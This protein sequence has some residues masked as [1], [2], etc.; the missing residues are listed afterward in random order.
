M[1]Q[2]SHNTSGRE[3]FPLDC[4]FILPL[5]GRLGEIS[6]P[7]SFVH[8]GCSATTRP[9]RPLGIVSKIKIWRKNSGKHSRNRWLLPLE[10][11]A[12][13]WSKALRPTLD[14]MAAQRV[15]GYLEK[16]R[17]GALFEVFSRC[18]VIIARPY[19]YIETQRILSMAA[20]QWSVFRSHKLSPS[21][22]VPGF[23]DVRSLN[24]YV[25]CL[26]CQSSRCDRSE[27]FVVIST[28]S[29][30]TIYPLHRFRLFWFN[31]RCICRPFTHAGWKLLFSN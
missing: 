2:N 22:V 27:D 25:I 7:H 18:F 23:V 11:C 9:H 8:S 13:N 10:F 26:F 31:T 17:I 24:V 4:C 30:A 1:P 20:A 29:N 21:A 15:Q 12:Q 28:A 3:H 16:H 14:N 5:A 19:F 6:G